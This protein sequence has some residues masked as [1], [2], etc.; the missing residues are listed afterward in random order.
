MGRNG[1]NKIVYEICLLLLTHPKLDISLVIKNLSFDTGSLWTILSPYFTKEQL[2]EVADL[3]YA[4]SDKS[5]T[6][7]A[8]MLKEMP[9][10]KR[11]KLF[12]ILYQ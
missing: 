6:I 4:K 5:L 1:T 10:E 2:P 12:E 7:D 9:A 11:R 3:F 8:K